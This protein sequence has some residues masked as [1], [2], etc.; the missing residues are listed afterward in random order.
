MLI[1]SVTLTS[2]QYDEFEMSSLPTRSNTEVNAM[3]LP[4]MWKTVYLASDT[5]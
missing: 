4:A 1:Q 3:S 5:Q 2:E